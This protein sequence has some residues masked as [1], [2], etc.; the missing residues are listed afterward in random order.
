MLFLRLE[1]GNL[2][3][4]ILSKV[5]SQCHVDYKHIFE[6]KIVRVLSEK[7][8]FKLDTAF[9]ILKSVAQFSV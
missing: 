4:N 1:N 5:K 2:E 3:K 6:S 7:N 8:V 9:A